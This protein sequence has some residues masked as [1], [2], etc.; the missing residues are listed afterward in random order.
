MKFAVINDLHAQFAPGSAFKGYPGA[1]ERAEW[2]LTQ[3]E[4]GGAL[5]DVDF[6]LS[7]GDLIHG[8]DL[9]SISAEMQALQQRLALLAVPFFP[10]CGNHEIRQAEGEAD[11]EAPYQEVFG[12]ERFDYLIPGDHADVVVL[13]NGGTFHVTAERREQRYLALKRMLATRP[14]VP[15]ILVCHVPLVCVRDHDTLAKSFGFTSYRCVEAEIL[16]LVEAPTAPVRLVIS[17][18]LHL[19]GMREQHGIKHLVTAGTASFPHDYAIVTV[20][21]NEIAVEV[22]RLPD[23]LHEPASNLHGP[24]R[25]PE[26]YTDAA[27]PTANSY[28]SGNPSERRFTVSLR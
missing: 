17:G 25:Y 23:S 22:C 9:P 3:F 1:N 5:T 8:E 4:S 14:E 6:V 18:H 16:D 19:T 27:H 2:M 13:N 26:P 12:T 21:E 28:L 11:Y 15:K 7:A 10:G 20:S 24:P